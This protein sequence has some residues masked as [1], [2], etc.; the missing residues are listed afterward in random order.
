MAVLVRV[1]PVDDSRPDPG[2]GRRR[3]AGRGRR[4]RDPAGRRPGRPAAAARRCRSRP[5]AARSPPTRRRLLLTSPLGGLDSMAIRRLGRALRDAER[6]ELAGSATAPAVRRADRA[7]PCAH[8]ELLDELPGRG[9]T[10]DGGPAA[11]RPAAAAAS[12]RSRRAAPPRRRCGCSGPAPAG[13]S[14]CGARPL[15]A[16][17]SG[18]RAN[19]DLDAVC[20][21]FDIAAR[22]EEVSGLRG[23]TG[24]L[25]EVEG[26][27]IPADT[28][29]RVRPARRRRSGCSPPTGPRAW[30]GSSSWSP[31]CRRGAG[32][33]Y[34]AAARCWSRTGSA[35]AG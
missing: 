26:Q 35:A 19:R 3:R 29:A 11:G 21:L 13:R 27:Q 14:G 25:A 17:T 24:F 33:T 32:P 8:P 18:R 2:A 7:R 20:A 23:V 10:V 12:G 28:A 9:T 31:G 4:G 5:G 30:S 1:R 6:A 16:A 34:A 15:A 22:S